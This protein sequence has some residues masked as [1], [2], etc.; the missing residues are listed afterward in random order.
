MSSRPFLLAVNCLKLK[1]SAT[2]AQIATI[3]RI[4]AGPCLALQKPTQGQ[5]E[6]QCG[7]HISLLTAVTEKTANIRGRFLLSYRHCR[8]NGE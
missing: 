7:A 6:G 2:L 8:H 5:T 1:T 4:G 3:R